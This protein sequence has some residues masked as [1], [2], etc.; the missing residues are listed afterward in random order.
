MEKGILKTEKGF[1][2]YINQK[3]YPTVRGLLNYLR[4]HS[5]TSE[6][7]YLK[8]LGETRKCEKCENSTTYNNIIVGYK[9][10][11]CSN[12]G[13]RSENHRK[14]VRERF[15]GHPQKLQDSLGK[16]KVSQSNKTEEEISK[17]HEK[18][19]Q[20][21][22]RKYGEDYFSRK[23]KLQWE[24]RTKEEVQSLVEKS[25]ATKRKNGTLGIPP[26]KYNRRKVV[27]QGKLFNI[28]GYEDIAINLLSEIVDVDKIKTGKEVPRIPLPSGKTYYPDILVDDLLIEVKSE[29]TYRI[30]LSESLVKQSASRKSGYR[31]IILVIH[32]KQLTKDRNLKDKQKYLK[33]LHMVI[34]SQASLEEGSTTI[35]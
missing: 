11:C 23:A 26:Y 22:H 14:A 33:I 13:L 10:Y 15:V 7:Y 4:T 29:Y 19:R 18:R 30:K 6:E 32:S 31:H 12:C 28:Q 27:V 21:I 20:T 5:M 34:S 3:F 16:R 35:P 25:N 9:P 17:T 8:Y 24:R 2:C 1:Y